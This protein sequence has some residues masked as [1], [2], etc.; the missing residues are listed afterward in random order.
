MLVI[1]IDKVLNYKPI[2]FFSVLTP[3]GK[4]TIR[5][6]TRRVCPCY[7]SL[8]YDKISEKVYSEYTKCKNNYT[9]PLRKK[10]PKYIVFNGQ[11]QL[12]PDYEYPSPFTLEPYIN[13]E[14]D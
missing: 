14:I 3:L 5:P 12:N 7:Q 11:Y 2:M 4:K 13:I 9:F 1:Y 8:A 10:E 6:C